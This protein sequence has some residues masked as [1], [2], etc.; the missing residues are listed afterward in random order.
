[1]WHQIGVY[2]PSYLR[3][4]S[5]RWTSPF[6]FF[7]LC[8]KFGRLRILSVKKFRVLSDAQT[9]WASGGLQTS[10]SSAYRFYGQYLIRTRV[11]QQC[12]WS[13]VAREAVRDELPSS[14]PTDR[15]A[16]PTHDEP[17]R[18]LAGTETTAAVDVERGGCCCSRPPRSCRAACWAAVL[19][20]VTTTVSTAGARIR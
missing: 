18:P 17:V 5:C 2:D 20:D 7:P 15:S 1:V 8:Q 12:A 13:G 14:Y 3:A 4:G 11:Y 9:E 19:S 16:P 6:F 10:L